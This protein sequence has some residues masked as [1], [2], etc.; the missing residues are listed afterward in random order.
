MTLEENTPYGTPKPD[1]N[2]EDWDVD[3]ESV[4]VEPSPWEDDPDPQPQGEM[5]QLGETQGE[6]F[7]LPEGAIAP[8]GQPLQAGL[9]SS[10]AS[11]SEDS[12]AGFYDDETNNWQDEDSNWDDDSDAYA[13]YDNIPHDPPPGDMLQ[14]PVNERTWQDHDDDDDDSDDDEVN[15]APVASELPEP[16]ESMAVMVSPIAATEDPQ[17]DPQ[18][19][20]QDESLY[21]PRDE[22]EPDNETSDQTEPTEP[23][24]VSPAVAQSTPTPESSPQPSPSQ[25]PSEPTASPAV[26]IEVD[27][28]EQRAEALRAEIAQLE[29]AKQ[30]TQQAQAEL[31]RDLGRLVQEG[32]SELKKRKQAL[33]VDIERLERRQERIRKEMQTSFAGVSQDIAVRVQGFKNYLVGSLQ[34][35]SVAAEQLQIEPPQAPAAAPTPVEGAPRRSRS[36][37]G[38]SRGEAA[39][40]P[41]FSEQGFQEQRRLIRRALDQY[42]N[43]PDYY[44][45]PWQLRRTF[46]PVH[47]ERVANWFFTQGGRGAMKSTNSRLQNI[48]IASAIASVL[49]LMY[50]R[51]LRVLVLANSPERL[52]EWR[53]GLQDCLGISRADFGPD[54]G[55]ALFEAPEPLAQRA[56]RFMQAGLMPLIIVDES[57]NQLSLGLLQF[58]LWLAF[59]PDPESTLVR[60]W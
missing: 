15:A 59:A 3:A 43:N 30:Q 49:Y 12:N 18:D 8:L 51:R 29:R 16:E 38:E 6:E 31:Q 42:R 21:P 53:R 26:Q 34:D 60:D 19:Q 47:A 5:G 40:S 10:D 2:S 37:W 24:P 27:A 7:G 56:E 36:E 55:V 9:D 45:P 48:L 32:V 33:T 52:G 39:T 28:L 54:R 46:E 58:P 57:E 4:P 35:L 11:T 25:P 13:D 23:E 41:Q 50:K 17:N 1:P 20:S 14:E 22:A 44:G